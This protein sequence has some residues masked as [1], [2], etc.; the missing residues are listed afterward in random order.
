MVSKNKKLHKKG[1]CLPRVIAVVPKGQRAGALLCSWD[2][3]VLQQGHLCHLNLHPCCSDALWMVWGSH[4]PTCFYPRSFVPSI[5]PAESI[6]GASSLS[7][8]PEGKPRIP[9]W[10]A[11]GWGSVEI[12]ICEAEIQTS[13]SRTDPIASLQYLLG[14]TTAAVCG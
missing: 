14:V 6:P 13:R 3:K 5:R 7:Q 4:L 8:T 9:T 12:L 1:T 11:E 10:N 2:D